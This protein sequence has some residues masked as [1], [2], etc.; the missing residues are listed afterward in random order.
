[1]KGRMATA[2]ARRVLGCMASP[3]VLREGWNAA[4]VS[5]ARSNCQWHLLC[6]GESRRITLQFHSRPWHAIA[7]RRAARALLAETTRFVHSR[8]TTIPTWKCSGLLCHRPQDWSRWL[9][10]ANGTTASHVLKRSSFA[11]ADRHLAKVLWS[12]PVTCGKG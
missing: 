5:C 11:R 10:A 8:A 7:V 12:G 3:D 9:R 4:V 6:N 1:V 2:E